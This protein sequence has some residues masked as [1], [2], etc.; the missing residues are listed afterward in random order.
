MNKNITQKGK[1]RYHA[2]K[3]D[4]TSI[5]QKMKENIFA[6]CPAKFQ[7]RLVAATIVEVL[8]LFDQGNYSFI[9]ESQGIL[10]REVFGN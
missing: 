3:S 6:W 10:K 7:G 1:F 9:K 2:N 5:L 8:S 4:M